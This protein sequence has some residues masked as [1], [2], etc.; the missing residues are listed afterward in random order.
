MRCKIDGWLE[1]KNCMRLC[2]CHT[3]QRN[4]PEPFNPRDPEATMPQATDEQREIMKQ[5][6]GSEVDDSGALRFLEARGWTFPGGI[7]EP[8]VPAHNPSAYELECVYF[9]C[10]EWDYGYHGKQDPIC[11]VARPL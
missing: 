3:D 5:W 4:M 11:R 1:N 2:D 10:D 8:P 9:L 6:F 7:C